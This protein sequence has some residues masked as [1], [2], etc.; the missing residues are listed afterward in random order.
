[1]AESAAD[2]LP[3]YKRVT[4][5]AI[6]YFKERAW[7]PAFAVSF[8]CGIVPVMG[9]RA[10]PK[11][12][13]QVRRASVR[14][15]A[16]QL[17]H[18]TKLLEEWRDDHLDD[19]DPNVR[20]PSKVV[21]LEFFE[22]CRCACPDTNFKPDLLDHLLGLIYVPNDYDPLPPVSMDFLE[23]AKAL[24]HYQRLALEGTLSAAK[25]AAP[26][27]ASAG[28]K[29]V[30]VRRSGSRGKFCTLKAE[31]LEARRLT[32]IEQRMDAAAVEAVMLQ[33]ACDGAH[34]KIAKSTPTRI[35]YLKEGETVLTEYTRRALRQF[36]NRR[37]VGPDGE[38]L[39]T[40]AL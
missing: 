9:C 16:M 5:L 28:G 17:R 22:W 14:A 32:P 35:L 7:T 37:P 24:E 30:L 10:I 13:M 20:P 12:G 11:R 2:R 6:E 15:T 3:Q 25:L 1:M 40:G 29:G 4:D 33:L 34:P 8:V 36:L 31:I 21:P 39:E 23:R 27:R 26:A 18:A 19:D 38:L